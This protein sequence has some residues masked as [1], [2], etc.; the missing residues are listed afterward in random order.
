MFERVGRWW[1]AIAAVAVVASSLGVAT[2]WSY[3]KTLWRGVGESVRDA[4]PISFD[5]KRLDGMISD[6]VPEIRRNQQAVAQLEVE[7]EYLEREIAQMRSRQQETLAE[8][9]KLRD[10]LGEKKSEYRFASHRPTAASKWKTISSGGWIVTRKAKR[11]STPNS[12]CWLSAS[13]RWRRPRPR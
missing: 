12:S 1:I 9:K 8:M 11:S 6:L 7:T 5:L 10:A 13:A 3:V 4:T 2:T